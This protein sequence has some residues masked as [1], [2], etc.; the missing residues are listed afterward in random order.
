MKI[1]WSGG[2]LDNTKW[3]WMNEFEIIKWNWMDQMKLD[4]L[5]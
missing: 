5:D 1:A 2:I 4:N 3:N